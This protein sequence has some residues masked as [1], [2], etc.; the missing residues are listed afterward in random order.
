MPGIHFQG[1]PILS[2][3]FNLHLRD[4]GPVPIH[5]ET[6]NADIAAVLY[7]CQPRHLAELEFRA[8]PIQGESVH[9]LHFKKE[10]LAIDIILSLHERKSRRASQ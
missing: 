7:R 4:K 1:K 9:I 5:F 8:G 10:T 3:R 6:A 2:H